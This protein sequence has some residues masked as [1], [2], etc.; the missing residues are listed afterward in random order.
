[1]PTFKELLELINNPPED[2]VPADL[3]TQL[4]AEYDKDIQSYT[5]SAATALERATLAETAR[6]AAEEAKTE[7]QRHNARLLKSIPANV[8]DDDDPAGD[9]HNTD[10][11]ESS[12]TIESMTEYK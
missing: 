3:A 9:D 6:N 5:D 4:Q 2:G 7:A 1:M 8:S 11:F 10:P 12:V